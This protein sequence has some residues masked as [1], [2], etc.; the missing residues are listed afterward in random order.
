M[1]FQTNQNKVE[2]KKCK[3]CGMD[4]PAQAK[5]WPL[6]CFINQLYVFKLQKVKNVL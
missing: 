5:V 2:T 1:E 4:I 6:I 3:H